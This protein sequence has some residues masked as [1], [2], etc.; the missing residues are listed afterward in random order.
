MN[1]IADL[2]ACFP[3]VQTCVHLN[4][5]GTSPIPRPAAEA[6]LAVT[7]ELMSDDSFVAFKNHE[8]RQTELRAAFG[9]MLHVA[10]AALAFVRNTSHGLSIAADAL[11]L[12]PG[13]NVV[14]PPL[15]YPANV[16]PWMAQKKRGV[17]TRI[18]PVR[19]ADTGLI[20]EEDLMAACDERT[21]V[22]SVSWV[23]WGTGQ[24]LDLGR[25]GAFCR[26][27]NIV[28]VADIVQGLGALD[29]DLGSLPVDIAAA[30]CHKWLLAP[31]GIGVLYVRPGLLPD[32]LPTNIGWNSV[33]DALKW[34]NIHFDLKNDS[35]RFE[36]GTPNILGTAGL[37]ASVRLLESA[38][39]EA[40]ERHVLEMADRLRNGL[41]ARGYRVISPDEAGRRSGIVAFRHPRF[42][43]EDVLSVLSVARV[44]AVVRCGKVRFSPHVE[45]HASDV[46]RAL[47]ALPV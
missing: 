10:P 13:D 4:H 42:A 23:Q 44:R 21:R 40:V 28:F 19:D 38:G 1:R 17:E 41:R 46:E 47:A 45:N 22:L 12:S 35:S 33:T 31:A 24:R 16:Y 37:L 5:A 43:N 9:R 2:R 36:E 11:P 27:R 8:K 29:C 26:Q 34:E 6:V 18:A 3:S 14:V 20:A 32:L 7:D 15:E 39:F 30:G 25:L